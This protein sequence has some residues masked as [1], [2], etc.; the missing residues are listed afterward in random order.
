[1]GDG[2]VEPDISLATYDVTF[3]Q[4]ASM[5]TRDGTKLSVNLYLPDAPGTFPCLLIQEG[6]GKTDSA[7]ARDLVRR[8]A[9]TT[10]PCR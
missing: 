7:Q 10:D 8:A 3:V 1:V 9:T 5:L 2:S 4:N 6:Y